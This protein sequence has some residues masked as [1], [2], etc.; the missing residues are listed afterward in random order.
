MEGRRSAL[1][2]FDRRHTSYAFGLRRSS[3]AA[4]V[5]GGAGSSADRR[6]ST[7]DSESLSQDSSPRTER[8]RGLARRV[9]GNVVENRHGMWLLRGERET[10]LES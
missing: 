2:L 5:R 10:W 4:A 8:W 6:N 9:L 3:S 1:G 7:P